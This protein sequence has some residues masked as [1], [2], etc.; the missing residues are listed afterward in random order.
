MAQLKL[1]AAYDV[2]QCARP[3]CTKAKVPA[4]REFEN[5][6]ISLRTLPILH[7]V[8]I[9]FGWATKW[10]RIGHFDFSSGVRYLTKLVGRPTHYRSLLGSGRSSSEMSILLPCYAYVLNLAGIT[11]PSESAS[12][13]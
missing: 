2:H 12:P 10:L 11:D 7:Q 8:E 3:R 4:E 1:G 5:A 9:T 6:Q 13:G